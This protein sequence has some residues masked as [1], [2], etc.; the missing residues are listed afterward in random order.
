MSSKTAAG[1]AVVLRAGSTRIACRETARGQPAT[2]PHQSASPD[3]ALSAERLVSRLCAPGQVVVERVGNALAQFDAR[4]PTHLV[5]PFAAHE[6]A[7]RAIRLRRIA[8]DRTGEADHLADQ[9][10]EREDRKVRTR[11]NV[12]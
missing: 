5:E 7:R 3:Y 1:P 9:F 2:R 6:L 10:C 8:G 4:P 12:D 11:A